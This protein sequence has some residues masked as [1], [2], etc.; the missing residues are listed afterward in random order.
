M[1]RTIIL[2]V[3][4][5]G[6][7]TGSLTLREE[8]RLRVFEKK[9]LR[10]IFGPKRDEV[11]GGWRKLH[12]EELRDLYSSPS[13]IRIIKSRRMRWAGHVARM[14]EKRNAYRLLVGKPEGKRPLGRPRRRWVDLSEIGWGGVDW[15]GLAQDREKWR[16]LVNAVMN[17]RVP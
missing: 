11:T 16:A 2:S 10:R 7:E 15:I 8:H 5:Y 9:V 17:L 13:A 4:L 14:A 3:T 1:Y 12:N 6:C